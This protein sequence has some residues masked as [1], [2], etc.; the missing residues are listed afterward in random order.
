MLLLTLIPYLTGCVLLSPIV[1]R[2]E[3]SEFLVS[4]ASTRVIKQPKVQFL[5]VTDIHEFCTQM[6]GDINRRQVYLACSKWSKSSGKCQIFLPHNVHAIIV[7]HEV[8][9]CFDGSFH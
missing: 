6:V 8:R 2:E 3:Y 4:T 5:T 7:G 1:D 9:H